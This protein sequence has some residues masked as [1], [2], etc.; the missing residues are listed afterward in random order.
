MSVDPRAGKPAEP[1][2]LANTPRLVTAFYTQCP[3]PSVREQR[4][5]FGT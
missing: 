2:M 3:D 1:A 5:G 4:V